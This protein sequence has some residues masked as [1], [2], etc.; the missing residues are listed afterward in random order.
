MVYYVLPTFDTERLRLVGRSGPRMTPS[1]GTPSCSATLAMVLSGA[2]AVR[3]RI[4]P[5]PSFSRTTLHNLN[6]DIYILSRIS[7]YD[8]PSIPRLHHALNQNYGGF[9]FILVWKY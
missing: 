5:T 8:P 7:Y 3:P 6:Q 2:V 4:V 1:P 9:N